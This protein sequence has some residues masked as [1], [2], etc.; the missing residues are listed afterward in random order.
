[1]IYVVDHI[2]GH[3]FGYNRPEQRRWARHHPQCAGKFQSPIA[4]YSSKVINMQR[5]YIKFINTY[6]HA[7]YTAKLK[8]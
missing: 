5:I 3:R 4:I 2:Q 8:L 7:Y 1:M 6:K